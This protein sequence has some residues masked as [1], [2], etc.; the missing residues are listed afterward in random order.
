MQGEEDDT[1]LEEPPKEQVVLPAHVS[2]DAVA[3]TA[4]A[5]ATRLDPHEAEPVEP[6]FVYALGRVDLRF[7]SLGIEKEFA[8]A[9][10][11]DTTSGLTDRQALRSV[12]DDPTN[13]Y[14]ARQ[15]CWLFLVEGLETYILFPRDPADFKLLIEAYREDPAGD[16]VDVVIGARGPLAPPEACNGVSVPILAFDQLYS[17]PK[18][19]LID[20]IPKPDSVTKSGEAQFRRAAGEVFDQIRHVADNAGAL[21]EHRALNYL[22]VRYP[23]LYAATAEANENNAS[24]SG[25]DV[26][27]SELSGTRK[28]FEVILSFTH[29]QTLATEKQFVRVDVTDEYPFLTMALSKYFDR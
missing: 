2:E 11:R 10:G 3:R 12:L 28:I 27:R 19:A 5:V 14:L 18:K 16:D 21:D 15:V 4:E 23:R 29:R 13:R 1:M 25:V 9:A 20:S 6:S 24:L 22:A 26:R 17:F 7:P 8:Q